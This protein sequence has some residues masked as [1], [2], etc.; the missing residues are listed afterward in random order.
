MKSV[1][2]EVILLMKSVMPE[3]ILLMKSVMP[4]VILLMVWSLL[5]TKVTDSSQSQ[6]N[7]P[8]DNG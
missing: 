6:Q 5:D 4:E 2:P 3:V 7:N 8:E 1:M